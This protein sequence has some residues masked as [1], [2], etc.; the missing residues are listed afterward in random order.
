[1]APGTGADAAG[2]MSMGGAGSGA[3]TTAAGAGAG[4]M[5]NAAVG[6][7]PETGRLA[8]ITAAHN[9]IRANVSTPTPNPPLPPLT[10]S[11]SLAATAQAYADKLATTGGCQLVHS[12]A[13]GLGENLAYYGGQMAS[14]EQAVGGWAG[15]VSCWTYGNFMQSDACDMACTSAMYTSGCGHYTQ[16]VWRDTTEVGC[17]VALCSSSGGF[18]SKEIWVCNY[19]PQGNYVTEKP[20]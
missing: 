15:E 5:E 16:L 12:G 3:G 6:P 17:G 10:W 1:M 11:E 4:S 19:T 18:S 13:P 9:A 8:G 2:S 20:Y 7:N 14:A